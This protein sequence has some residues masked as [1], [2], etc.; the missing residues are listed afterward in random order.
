MSLELVTGHTGTAHITAEQV[1][2]LQQGIISDD[3]AKL[4]RFNTGNQCEVSVVD[5]LQVQINTGNAIASGRHFQVTAAETFDIDPTNSGYSRI[6]GIFF[7]IISDNETSVESCQFVTVKGN[8]Y[9]TTT[10]IPNVPDTP[11]SVDDTH[12]LLICV[13]VAYVYVSYQ[14]I[15]TLEDETVAYPN[16]LDFANRISTAE[17]D[18]DNI[19]TDI[20]TMQTT[21]QAGVDTIYNGLTTRGMSPSASTPNALADAVGEGLG[22]LY[23][24]AW[25]YGH[26]SGVG[27]DD[28]TMDEVKSA[29]T[30]ITEVT[31]PET[32]IGYINGGGTVVY[33][34]KNATTIQLQ[35]D[36][37]AYVGFKNTAGGSAVS[38]IQ[39]SAGTHTLT[40]S[41][42]FIE[43]YQTDSIYPIM[44]T[45]TI[46]RQAKVLR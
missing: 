45:L 38:T 18:I 22:S 2:S 13:P 6:D 21:F 28:A 44:Y 27:H 36:A 31:W 34:T 41:T 25:S 19:E 23:D 16:A 5:D 15:S 8:E 37:P 3:S 4:Y 46:T 11:T 12:T 39:L 33:S 24:Y 43:M 32:V 35:I 40:P 42:A 9:L 7:E 17:N 10:G 30:A 1:A 26:D 29:I 20:E 14:T